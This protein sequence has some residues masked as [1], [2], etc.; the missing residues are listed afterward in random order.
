MTVLREPFPVHP[1]GDDARPVREPKPSRD[2]E[3]QAR[4]L[5]VDDVPDDEL[6]PLHAATARRMAEAGARLHAPPDDLRVVLCALGVVDDGQGTHTSRWGTRLGPAREPTA[7]PAAETGP[8][9]AVAD[10]TIEGHAPADAE[11]PTAQ[12]EA[13]QDPSAPEPPPTSDTPDGLTVWQVPRGVA[14][15]P[16]LCPQ[17]AGQTVC[18]GTRLSD[19]IAKPVPPAQVPPDRRCSANACAAR[20]R[21]WTAGQLLRFRCD[22]CRTHHTHEESA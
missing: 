13:K 20:W 18:S 22:R 19:T 6:A 16:N 17:R 9:T 11:P 5:D 8:E 21:R 2:P 3:R 7:G 12:P 15:W 4:M 14:H 10:P 1:H